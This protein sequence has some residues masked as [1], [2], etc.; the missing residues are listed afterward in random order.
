MISA[1]PYFHFLNRPF[2]SH[3]ELR[4]LV[5]F[6]MHPGKISPDGAIY[7][8][9]ANDQNA[10]SDGRLTYPRQTRL[11]PDSFAEY[12]PRSAAATSASELACVSGSI[13]AAPML[14]VS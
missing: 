8:A 11:R 12:R 13:V 1:P 7:P 3:P 14:I 10:P 4:F 6:F 5:G 9:A 2:E